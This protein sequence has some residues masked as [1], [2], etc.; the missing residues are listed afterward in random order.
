MIYRLYDCGEEHIGR[1]SNITQ[2]KKMIIFSP[3][4]NVIEYNFTAE[5]ISQKFFKKV[6]AASQV[7]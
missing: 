2:K 6:S 1:M 3:D 4:T 5:E 7:A